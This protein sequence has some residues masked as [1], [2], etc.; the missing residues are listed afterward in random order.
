[1]NSVAKNGRN[2]DWVRIFIYSAGIGAGIICF[3]LFPHYGL[4][5]EDLQSS[6]STIFAIFGGIQLAIFAALS[7]L[8]VDGFRTAFTK[9][10]AN[11]SIANRFGRQVILFYAYIIVVSLIVIDQAFNFCS[12][13]ALIGRIY[14]SL[15]VASLIWSLELP[16]ALSSVHND[17][18]DSK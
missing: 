17:A 10:A 3:I 18:T 11:R 4:I 8:R 12:Y 1:M 14:V 16:R 13:E 15:A 7:S 2:F 6:I 5:T 9:N